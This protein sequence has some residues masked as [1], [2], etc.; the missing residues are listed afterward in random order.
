[1]DIAGA[2]E[3]GER[4]VAPGTPINV[5]RKK[6]KRVAPGA[7]A[8]GSAAQPALGN[9]KATLVCTAINPG[10][11]NASA[12]APCAKVQ[13]VEALSKTRARAEREHGHIHSSKAN[14][15]SEARMGLVSDHLRRQISEAQ[16]L[17]EVGHVLTPTTLF[18]SSL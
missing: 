8:A 4:R 18:A 14:L 7:A 13:D 17:M 2:R 9:Q 5:L 12:R 1:M 16:M 15:R 6:L 11:K 3:A 10:P